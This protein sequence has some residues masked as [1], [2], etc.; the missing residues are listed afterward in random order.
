MTVGGRTAS[1]WRLDG[2]GPAIVLVHSAGRNQRAF[3][4]VLPFLAG[5]EVLVP[6][7]PGRGASEGPHCGT[8]AES[9]RWL[10]SLLDELDVRDAL[11]AGHSVGGAIAIELALSAHRERVSRLALISTG[12]RLRVLP[13]ILSTLEDA[14]ARGAQPDLSAWLGPNRDSAHAGTPPA[15]TLADW[16]MANGFDRMANVASISVP[17]RV[18]S[19][20]ADPLTP[21]KYAAFLRDAIPGAT[22]VSFEGAGH[23]LPFDRPAEV[24]AD[25]ADFSAK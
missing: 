18:L 5:R 14:A 7:F 2:K 13:A 17:T 15:A 20:T 1:A 21:P 23:D 8:I 4:A 25:L 9:A 3:D 16:R 6:S 11:V 10:A 24:A 12:A 19:G 22:L